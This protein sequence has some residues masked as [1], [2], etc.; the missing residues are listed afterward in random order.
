MPRTA[1]NIVGNKYG[2]LTVISRAESS[3]NGQTRWKC[4]CE[5]GNETIVFKSNLISGSVKSCGCKRNDSLSEIHKTH[6]Y[7]NTRLYRIY[8]AMKRR[9]YSPKHDN[10]DKYGGRG[11]KICEEWLG[12]NG[13][14]TF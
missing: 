13:F 1:K 4:L 11:I 3:L 7:A 10:Y 5:C 2:H 12:E 14:I 8:Y 9:C 6:G